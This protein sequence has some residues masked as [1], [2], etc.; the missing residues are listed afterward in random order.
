VLLKL[1]FMQPH[2]IHITGV[3]VRGTRV[4]GGQMCVCV[5]VC[6]CVCPCVSVSVCICVCVCVVPHLT[7]PLTHRHTCLHA[8]GQHFLHCWVQ[9]QASELKGEIGAGK[10][11]AF[12]PS[13]NTEAEA[14]IAP[15]HAQHEEQPRAGNEGTAVGGAAL[16]GNRSVN[17]D[18]NTGENG[19]SEEVATLAGVDDI[20][21]VPWRPGCTPQ[22]NRQQVEEEGGNEVVAVVVTSEPKVQAKITFDAPAVAAHKSSSN[23]AFAQMVRSRSNNNGEHENDTSYISDATV[24]VV[25]VHATTTVGEVGGGEVDAAV[26]EPGVEEEGGSG[27][28]GVVTSEQKVEARVTFDPPAGAGAGAAHDNSKFAEMVRLR[29]DTSSHENDTSCV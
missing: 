13:R 16:K 27:E 22:G 6:V 14:D 19:A 26:S 23:D 7:S 29:S 21:A 3:E 8:G 4:R 20:D 24:A 18:S 1:T 10:D 2:R 11:E 9:A 25:P 5:C 15:P 12:V 28:D 17:G